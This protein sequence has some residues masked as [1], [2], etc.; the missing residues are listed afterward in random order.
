MSNEYPE[1]VV[2]AQAFVLKD[3]AGVE[4]DVL[5]VDKEEPSLRLRDARGQTRAD[6]RLEKDGLCLR[7]QAASGLAKLIVKLAEDALSFSVSGPR[8]GA[9]T[10]LRSSADGLE[11][12]VFG[13]DREPPASVKVNLDS[14]GL[15]V[16]DYGGALLWSM[17]A[18]K[19][20]ST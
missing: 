11:L 4:R 2:E 18:P 3:E 15:S 9:E 13:W 12:Q 5:T 8:L 19:T 20:Q 14:A 1:R 17:P 7:L 16:R 6:V 10:A